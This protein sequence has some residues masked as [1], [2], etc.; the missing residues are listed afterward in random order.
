LLNP[1]TMVKQPSSLR[2][3]K[4][5]ETMKA[6]GAGREKEQRGSVFR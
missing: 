2:T 3:I 4:E 6:E 5:Q 1:N